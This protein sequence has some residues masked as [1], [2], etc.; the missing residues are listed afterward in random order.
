MLDFVHSFE[1]LSFS[2]GDYSQQNKIQNEKK[3]F[4]SVYTHF[5]CEIYIKNRCIDLIKYFL[6]KIKKKNKEN[7]IEFAFYKDGNCTLI[8]INTKDKFP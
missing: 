7:R 8:K 5:S 2:F 3:T 4:T 1:I 6:N